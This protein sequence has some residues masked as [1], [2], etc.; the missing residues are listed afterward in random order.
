MRA[1]K[2]KGKNVFDF[3]LHLFLA[4]FGKI[5]LFPCRDF[6]FRL[7]YKREDSIEN[8]LCFKMKIFTSSFAS[9]THNQG[10]GDL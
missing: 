8:V 2:K 3:L 4:E 7:R 1:L 5:V 10:V 9:Q 6:D